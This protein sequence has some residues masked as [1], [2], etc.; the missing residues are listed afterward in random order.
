MCL[1]GTVRHYIFPGLLT[2]RSGEREAVVMHVYIKSQQ[3]GSTVVVRGFMFAESV[4]RQ[5]YSYEDGYVC[6][7]DIS[8]DAWPG[9]S[10]RRAAAHGLLAYM[11]PCSVVR[12]GMWQGGGVLTA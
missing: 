10:L 2:V 8:Q 1:A 6:Q 5:W 9:I 12:E 4:E 11:H 7:P 3:Q